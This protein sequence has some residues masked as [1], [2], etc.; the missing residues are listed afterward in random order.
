MEKSVRIVLAKK[1]DLVVGDTFQLYYNS[2]IEAPDP[3]IYA[4]VAICEKGSNYPRYFEYTPAS[5]GQHKLKIQLYNA[6]REIVGEGETLLNVVLPCENNTNVNVLCIGDS[7]TANGKWVAEVNRRIS[8]Q[9]GNPEG[10]GYSNVH[11]VGSCQK[12]GVGFE[13]FG[14]WTWDR[15]T[16]DKQGSMWIES[17]NNRTQEDQHSLWQDENGAI[18]QLETL[19][20]DYMKFNRYRDHDSPRPKGGCLIHYKNALNTNPIPILSSSDE[21]SSPFFDPE[22]HKIDFKAYAKRNQITKIDAAY[23]FLGANGLMRQEAMSRSR[24][25]YCKLVV[26]EAKVLV[27]RLKEDYP[28]VK[29][30]IISPQ[31][32]S[33]NGALGYAYGAELPFTNGFDIKH[34]KF[35]LRLAYENWTK[36]PFYRDFMEFIDLTGQFDAEYNY[37]YME[38]PVN[39]RST[40]TERIDTN[41]AHPTDAGYMQMAD[42]VYRNV[43]KEFCSQK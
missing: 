31:L 4:I 41:A 20:I 5:E 30:K 22:T 17:P 1:Y 37:P 23:I 25:E 12:E 14:G 35:E 32:P 18:W 43:I 2:I 16:S 15:F 40:Q 19:Q 33:P 27:D 34:Y 6:N 39:T 13:A 9:G 7:L 38:K 24:H 8:G 26:A 29:V 21:K 28:D 42:A 10:L 36:E 3:Y 11:F